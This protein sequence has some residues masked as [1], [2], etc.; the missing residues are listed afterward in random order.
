MKCSNCSEDAE[1]TISP[2]YASTVHYCI[3]HIPQYLRLGASEGLYPVEGSQKT[4][5][6][7]KKTS[8]EDSE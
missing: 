5:S 4:K 2:V 7:K 8:E 6:D 3:K 1:Y